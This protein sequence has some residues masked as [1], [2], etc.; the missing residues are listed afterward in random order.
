M[1]PAM[2]PRANASLSSVQETSEIASARLISLSS[3]RGRDWALTMAMSRRASKERTHRG[4]IKGTLQVLLERGPADLTTGRIAKAAGVAQP[5]FYVHFSDMSDA[6]N[7]AADW[8]ESRL[9][10]SLRESRK[11][12]TFGSP[13]ETV[14][15][16][17]K[18]SVE[19]LVQEPGL[20][21]L[22][23]R[24]RRDFASPLGQRFAQMHQRAQEGLLR[25]LRSM[26]M[27]DEMVPDLAVHAQL[28]TAMTLSVVEAILD[29]TL[30]DP[31]PCYDSIAR[32]AV[33]TSEGWL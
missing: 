18:Q 4:L 2:A 26:G 22:F 11:S 8:V 27:T 32:M 24:Y 23:L 6:L 12:I 20:S 3:R 17:F 15:S 25:D 21:T 13:L 5:T 7:Q 29:G 10:A 16:A 28:L 31:E 14:R 19:A 9:D 33:R 30:K 1:V